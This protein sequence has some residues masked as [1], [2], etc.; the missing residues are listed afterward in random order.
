M[1]SRCAELVRRGGAVVAVMVATGVMAQQ[2]GSHAMISLSAG[3]GEGGQM[4]IVTSEVRDG[5]TNTTTVVTN[6]GGR[7]RGFNVFGNLLTNSQHRTGSWRRL[8]A[9]RPVADGKPTPWLGVA[10]QEVPAMLRSQI[11]IEAGV[12]LVVTQVSE[13]SPAQKAGV[14]D[15]DILTRF[16]DQILTNSSQ[17]RILIQKKK[18]G[19][20][21]ALKA[22][23]QGKEIALTAT[24]A[25]HVPDAYSG[26]F[27]SGEDGAAMQNDMRELVQSWMGNPG[28]ANDARTAEGLAVRLLSGTSA[29]PTGTVDKLVQQLKDLAVQNREEVLS[30]VEDLVEQ[31][32][33]PP[34][35][36][37][38]AR[39]KK[40]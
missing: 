30:K 26:L 37:A 20:V 16:D 6:F 23:R 18:A 29:A 13:D 32:S 11:A 39:P 9:G 17:L 24:I 3:A 1:N 2:S 33:P 36:P 7:G 15:H 38:L 22:I 34:A 14:L 28:A 40:K 35:A 12:G 8:G 25:V 27:G 21:V 31:L 5:V 10:V 4:R 19:D